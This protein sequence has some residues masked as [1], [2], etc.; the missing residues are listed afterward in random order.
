[1][2]YE[3]RGAARLNTQADFKVP[4]PFSTHG[5]PESLCT[6]VLSCVYLGL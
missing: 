5:L 1:M 4:D 3:P 2:R 6:S